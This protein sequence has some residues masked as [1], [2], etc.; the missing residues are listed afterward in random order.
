M[1]YTTFLFLHRTFLDKINIK[2]SHLVGVDDESMQ[3][4]ASVLFVGH[5]VSCAQFDYLF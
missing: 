4:D 1:V 2:L 5:G 3:T